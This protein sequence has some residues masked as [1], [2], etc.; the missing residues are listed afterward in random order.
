MSDAV[1]ERMISTFLATD[2]PVHGFGW[3][4]GEPT[5]MGLDFFR[6][7]TDWQKKY[8]RPGGAVSNGLQTNATLI[9][10]DM[11]RLFAEYNFLLGVSLDGPAHIHDRYRVNAAG[12][13]THARVLHSI[14]TLR[15]HRVE[16][17]TLTLV[18]EANAGRAVEVYDWLVRQD[19]LY[20]QYIP[21]V[22]FD[23]RGRLLPFSVT[24]DAWG[25]FLCDLFD[26]WYAGDTRR[27]SI[28][29]FDALLHI[30]VDQRV[31]VCHLGRDCREYFVVEHNG[32]LYPCDFFVRDDLRIGNVFDTTWEQALDSDAYARFGCQKS[33]WN[34]R[35]AQCRRLGLCAGDCLKHRLTPNGDARTLSVLCGGITRF[36]DHAFDRLQAL[37][38]AVRADRRMADS[39]LPATGDAGAARN[40]PCP[41]GSGRKFKKCCGRT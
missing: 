8:G 25:E 41:C 28:R 11:A 40:D 30:L 19:C 2:Q 20:H 3:Q 39:L 33:C 32:D 18:T 26:R 35:C 31:V 13:G 16:F 14:E 23:D 27:V 22:E 17:N 9:T 6:K 5:L 15:R 38:D 29:Y 12:A 36:L 10:D 21:C 1:L 24:G 34:E 7:V 37:A 4:G